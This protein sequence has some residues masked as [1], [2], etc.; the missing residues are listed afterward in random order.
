MTRLLDDLAAGLLAAYDLRTRNRWEAP[1][2]A[3]A[4]YEAIRGDLAAGGLDPYRERYDVLATRLALDSVQRRLL[5]V[6]LLAEIHP[7]AYTLMGVLTGGDGAAR[8]TAA[9]ALEIAQVPTSDD[10][11]WRALAPDAELRRS[12]AVSLSGDG[13]LLSRRIRVHDAVVRHLHG[14]ETASPWLRPLLTELPFLLAPDQPSPVAR[15]LRAGQPLVWVH[16]PVGTVGASLATHACFELDA[17]YLAADLTRLVTAS[18]PSSGAP[19]DGSAAG[20][21]SRLP[22]ESDVRSVAAELCLEATLDGSLLVLLGAHL[23]GPAMTDLVRSPTPVIAVGQSDW[24]PQ[25]YPE[26]PILLTAQRLGIKDRTQAWREALGLTE[27]SRDITALRLTPEEIASVGRA[28]VRIRETTGEPVTTELVTRTARALSSRGGHQTT[29]GRTPAQL[30]DLVLPAHT[31]SE[32]NRL[33]GWGRYRD[34]VL[35]SADLQGKGGKGSG[36]A[37]LFSGSPGTGK[38][39]AAHVVADTLGME[40]MQVDLSSIVDKYVGETEKNLERVFTAAESLNCV[41]FFDEADSLFGSRSA[42]T[43]SRDRYANQEVAYLLQRIEAFDGITV[44]ATNLRGNLDPA[45]ARRLHFMIHFPD[46]DEQ[47][48][49]HLWEHHL[50]QVAAIDSTDP[51]RVPLLAGA[52]ELAGGDIRNIVLAAAYDAVSSD[53]PVSMAHVRH[54]AAREFAKLGRR[55]SASALGMDEASSTGDEL[56]KLT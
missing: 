15:A 33:I 44:L 42:V 43:D 14:D 45:F 12:G 9:L 34:D 5:G 3:A 39:L 29:K 50:A 48:R 24:N 36:I 13:V 7:A 40:L 20:T 54:A 28:V 51:P 17:T 37:A 38:T 10:L 55:L 11:A 6:G 53:Q 47:T 49:V 35:A 32:I 23:A 56:A 30:S 19:A 2:A 16:S 8:P 21:G 25:W 52:L 22:A 26:L 4:A 1:A 18:G 31:L 27:P 41:L 46:P